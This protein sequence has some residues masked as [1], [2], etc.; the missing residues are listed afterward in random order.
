MTTMKYTKEELE[1]AFN[2]KL[3]D[4]PWST[5][6]FMGSGTKYKVGDRVRLKPLTEL[7][8]SQWIA[9]YSF[10]GNYV[11]LDIGDPEY[12]AS[13]TIN[14]TQYPMYDVKIINVGITEYRDYEEHYYYRWADEEGRGNWLEL[15]MIQE[16]DPGLLAIEKFKRWKQ[17]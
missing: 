1:A 17:C 2:N 7:L 8:R 4:D 6:E 13:F 16:D 11:S 14:Y 10:D 3:N 12:D 9:G 15:W 5:L